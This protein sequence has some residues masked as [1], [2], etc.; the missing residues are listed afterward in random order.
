MLYKEQLEI[1]SALSRK[2]D[3]GLLQSQDKEILPLSFFSSSYDILKQMMSLLQTVEESQVEQMRQQLLLHK[4]TI[5]RQ[6]VPTEGQGSD[7]RK[8]EDTPAAIVK[9][10]VFVPKEAPKAEATEQPAPEIVRAN[11]VEWKITI[12]D[13][14]LFMK[15]LFSNDKALMEEVLDHLG[16]L[17]SLAEALEYLDNRFHWDNEKEAPAIFRLLLEKTYV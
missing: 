8:N 7:D 11:R 14:F 4:S 13:R 6:M 15:E 17:S 5:G 16:A 10:E 1:L 2:F 12:S 3:A 9:E